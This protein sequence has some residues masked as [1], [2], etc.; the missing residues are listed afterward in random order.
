M[1]WHTFLSYSRQQYHFAESLASALQARGVTVW[2]DVQQLEPG[3]RWQQDIDDG[4][5]NS[6]TVILLASRASL[7]SPYVAREW[8]SALQQGKPVIVALIERVRLPPALRR[9]PLI[10]CRGDFDAA[11][12]RLQIALQNPVYPHGVGAAP[13]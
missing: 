13:A 2:F 6:G 10:D 12:G 3:T 11:V 7:D 9:A 4:L 1:S 8:G 5:A